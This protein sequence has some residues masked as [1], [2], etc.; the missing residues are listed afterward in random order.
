VP[1]SSEV[2]LYVTEQLPDTR[3]QVEALNVPV[4]L[5]DQATLPVGVLTV[6]GEVSVTVAA[7]VEGEPTWTEPGLQ[8][9]V[10]VMLRLLTVRLVLPELV[11]CVE[12]P[13]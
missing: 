4:P 7:H 10:A 5:V 13:P 8:F 6:P 2:A 9:T 12:S 11:A 1:E 3:V